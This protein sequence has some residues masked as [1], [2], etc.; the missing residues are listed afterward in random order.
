VHPS[1]GVDTLDA[2]NVVSEGITFDS[3][4]ESNLRIKRR[5]EVY[6]IES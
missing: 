2:A 1:Y 3:S 6:A 4:N 5:I